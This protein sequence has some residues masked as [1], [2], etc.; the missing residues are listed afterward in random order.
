MC[1]SRVINFGRASTK[2]ALVLA[3]AVMGNTPSTA[4]AT[5]D[6]LVRHVGLPTIGERHVVR[7]GGWAPV[8]VDIG[9]Q[10][11]DEANFDGY[12][13]I[14]QPDNDGDFCY[15]TV[16]VHLLGGL[17][18]PDSRRY[19]LYTLPNPVRGQ[20][21]YAVEVYDMEGEIVEV[22]SDGELTTHA[23]VK[24]PPVAISDDH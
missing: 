18:P 4:R 7:G 12:L 3:F 10:E 22:L 11:G 17:T 6:V 16:E 23:T 1:R 14:T 2:T 15:D 21:T 24:Q 9:L 8:I 19:Y 20:E 13:K 5:L